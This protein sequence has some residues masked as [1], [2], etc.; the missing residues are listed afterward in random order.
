MKKRDKCTVIVPTLNAGTIWKRW[1]EGIKIQ[2]GNF[3]DVLVLDSESDDNTVFDSRAAGLRMVEIKRQDFNHGG[4][5]QYGVMLC[6]NA[7]IIIFLTQD[8]ILADQISL[9]ELIRAFDDPK[10]G[11]AFGRQLP[12]SGAG[13]LAAHARLF[14]Y[15]DKSSVKSKEDAKRL[16][17]KVAFISNSFA[18]YRRTALLE[19]GGFPGNTILS[20]DTYVAA[21]ML[22]AGWKIAY[23]ADARVYHS[24]DYTYWQ[25]F[26][27]YFD[28]G[29]FHAKEPWIRERF[30]QAEGEGA[31]FV[32]SEMR[33]LA[34][35][36]NWHLLP[37]ACIRTVLKYL[38][39]KLG[40][41]EQR[42][43]VAVKQRLSMHRRYWQERSARIEI[44]SG[45]KMGG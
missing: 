4:T 2:N 14:N 23:C 30:G 26:K 37:S 16:G 32:I 20:E 31:R 1:I 45:N 11:A 13:P 29:V 40:M 38:G 19:A 21:K 9:A 18:A 33:Y 27:R 10:V 7:E 35:T 17:I 36:G 3:G 5:R 34:S 28:I 22:L 12:H 44:L 24:H 39:Y 43:P 41:Q 25:E 42:L 8:A 6:P 15:P